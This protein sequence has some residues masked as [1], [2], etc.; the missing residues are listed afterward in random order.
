[1][2]DQPYLEVLT[3]SIA[4][5]PLVDPEAYDELVYEMLHRVV[6]RTIEL[7]SKADT[8]HTPSDDDLDDNSEIE[9]GLSSEG[10]VNIIRSQA[11]FTPSE[12]AEFQS[13]GM[14]LNMLISVSVARRSSLYYDTTPEES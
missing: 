5:E 9:E 4:F 14:L 12:R 2:L 13:T 11:N 7:A 10:F 3:M 6:D 1:L 8:A